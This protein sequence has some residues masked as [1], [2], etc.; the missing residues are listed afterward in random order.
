MK[1]DIQKPSSKLILAVFLLAGIFVGFFVF[2]LVNKDKSNAQESEKKPSY[3]YD[4]INQVVGNIEIGKLMTEGAVTPDATKQ[5]VKGINRGI[6]MSMNYVYSGMLIDVTSSTS[7]GLAKSNFENN[8][9][10]FYA[11]LANLREPINGDYYEGWLV[12]KDPF[13]FVSTGKIEKIGGE[14]INLYKS[15]MDLSDYNLY[16]VTMEENDGNSSPAKHILEGILTV[17][18]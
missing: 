7:S 11:T 9:Y 10:N 8:E 14:Y 3:I 17:D 1:I 5:E 6:M 13:G 4:D 2:K 18:R 12:R 16:V 15:N